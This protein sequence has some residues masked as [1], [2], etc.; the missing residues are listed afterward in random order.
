MGFY[1]SENFFLQANFVTFQERGAV[2]FAAMEAVPRG[3]V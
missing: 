1:K 2:G 3:R